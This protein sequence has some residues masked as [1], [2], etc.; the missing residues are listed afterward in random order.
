MGFI[1]KITVRNNKLYLSIYSD[2]TK[3]KITFR[4]DKI[5]NVENVNFEVCKTP[6]LKKTYRYLITRNFFENNPIL[7]TEKVLSIYEDFVEIENLEE[8]DFFVLQRLLTIGKNCIKI[9]DETI[10]EKILDI[11]NST[12]GVYE[13][14]QIQ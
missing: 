4:I 7:K 3:N 5:K 8:D 11:L 12:L 2:L 13:K 14:C 9:Y 6:I 10:K 1:D